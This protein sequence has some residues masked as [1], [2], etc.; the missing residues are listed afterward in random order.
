MQPDL[1]KKQLLEDL[2]QPVKFFLLLLVAGI[3][4]FMY[5]KFDDF[6]QRNPDGSYEL[7]KKRRDQIQDQLD[8]MDEAELYYLLARVD[9]Y[10]QCSHCPQGS[11]FLYKGE[12]A[13]IGT[14]V[15]GE[16]GRYKPKY[17]KRMNLR[18]LTVDEGDVSYILRK[19][20]EHIRDYPLMPENLQRPDEPQGKVLRYKLA[21]PP[22]NLQDQ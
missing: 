20:K 11:F 9:G 16:I 18:Y 22:L 12:I 13:K 3:C 19:E 17:L 10:Y 2:P 14:T 8:R 5:E 7:K 4:W 15:R 1:R 6:V 21:R